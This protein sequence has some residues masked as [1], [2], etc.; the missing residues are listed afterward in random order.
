MFTPLH[1]RLEYSY[2][3]LSKLC[4]HG[5]ARIDIIWMQPLVEAILFTLEVAKG[6]VALEVVVTRT[7]ST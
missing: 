6:Y 5:I 1:T 7:L 4:F 3:C 2:D